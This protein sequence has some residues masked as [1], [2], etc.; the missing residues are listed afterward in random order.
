[1]RFSQ[2]QAIALER[3]LLGAHVK[4]LYSSVTISNSSS[5]IAA[6]IQEHYVG[7]SLDTVRDEP[8][9]AF[10]WRVSSFRIQL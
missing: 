4:N 1:M 7:M 9:K 3:L 8:S 10:D 2:A 5:T 6:A